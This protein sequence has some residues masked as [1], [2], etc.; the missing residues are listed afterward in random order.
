MIAHDPAVPGRLWLAYSWPHV[1]PGRAPDGTTALMAAVSTHL[2]RSDDGGASFA[3]VGEPWPA[4]RR[5]DPE[6]SG[7]VGVISSETP[8][9]VAVDSGGVVTWYGAHLRYFLRPETGYHPKY[10]TSWHLRVGAAASP[11]ELATAEEAVL[12]VSAT[13]AVYAPDVRLDVLAGLSLTRC[14]MINNPGLFASGGTLYLVVECLAF[15]GPTLDVANSTTHV[16]ATTPAGPPPTWAWRHAGR[17]A[18][19]ELARELGADTVLQ[20]ELTRAV[21]GTSLFLVTPADEDPT[22]VVG[23]VGEGCIALELA[24][25]EPPTLRRDCE[26]RAVSRARVTGAGFGAC[27]YDPASNT[28][29][30]TT[31]KIGDGSWTLHASGLRP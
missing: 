2:A 8:S 11:S 27:A 29:I 18:G 9:L 17:L 25:L 24:S 14:A 30:V 3:Y 19:Q 20:P 22:V 31:S 7:E 4:V 23:T 28:G 12:G 13:A 6:G 1:L 16:F 15:V 21:D 10:A 5:P 26:G